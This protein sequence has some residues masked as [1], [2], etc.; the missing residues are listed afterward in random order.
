MSAINECNKI[1]AT[2]DINLE[3]I[4][5]YKTSCRLLLSIIEFLS[6]NRNQ[7]PMVY[8][9]FNHMVVNLENRKAHGTDSIET[10]VKDFAVERQRELAISTSR[11]FRDI[12]DVRIVCLIFY[13]SIVNSIQF[14]SPQ[15]LISSFKYHV[16][17]ECM[18]IFGATPYTAKEAFVVNLPAINKNH[19]PENHLTTLRQ[20]TQK[21]LL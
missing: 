4:V 10:A 15:I 17:E 5:T 6:F 20:T 13:R 14:S 21:V 12:G 9:T 18:I 19:F 16:I 1:A 11:K 2:V 3:A 8:E 7:I